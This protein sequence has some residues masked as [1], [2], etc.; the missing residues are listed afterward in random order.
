MKKY[1]S[2]LLA[3]IALISFCISFRI[4]AFADEEL[5]ATPAA[6][7]SEQL[8]KLMEDFA[9]NL[10]PGTAGSSLTAVK[11]AVRL[12][13]WGTV[14]KMTDDDICLTVLRYLLDKDDA[15]AEEYTQKLEQLNETYQLL[16]TEG[17]EELL[18]SAGCTGTAYPWGG[19]P[20]NAVEAFFEAA[21]I[22]IYTGDY[23]EFLDTYCQAISESWSVEKL[24]AAGIN[25][26]NCDFFKRPDALDLF[27]FTV[28]DINHDGVEELLVGPVNDAQT[29]NDLYTLCDGNRELVIQGGAYNENYFVCS[30]GT[31]CRY[32]YRNE[33]SKGY[34]YFTLNNGWLVPFGCLVF[35]ATVDPFNL[36]F[37]G[38]DDSWDVRGFSYYPADM[39]MQMIQSYEAKYDDNNYTPF[40]E[41]SDG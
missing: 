19:E 10:R 25:I 11:E 12:M 38:D 18:E 13:D 26:N 40:S 27:G 29:V 31:V 14:T 15:F 22:G 28:R 21:G 16:L 3:C 39:A 5:S 7:E 30:D 8:E 32:T 4:T 35:D 23:A 36:W 37:I 20:I 2:L 41:L 24:A 6:N 1:T 17:Q 34:H 9:E 33:S